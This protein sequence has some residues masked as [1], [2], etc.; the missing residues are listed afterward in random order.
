MNPKPHLQHELLP[1]ETVKATSESSFESRNTLDF[2]SVEDLLRY[3]RS[4]ISIPE[5]LK[6]RL[7][8]QVHV[9]SEEPPVWLKR[10]I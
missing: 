5:T 4:Q 7:A 1:N 10:W 8:E 6:Q 3:D 2:N 9:P